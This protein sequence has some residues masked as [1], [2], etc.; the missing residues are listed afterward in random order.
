MAFTLGIRDQVGTLTV[1]ADPK[2][3]A[4][5]L[6]LALGGH[7]PYRPLPSTSPAIDNGVETGGVDQRGVARISNVDSG[8]YEYVP[9]NISGSTGIAGAN[10]TYTDG[11]EKTAT[12]DASGLYSI[13]VPPL[14]TGTVTPS[15][16]GYTFAPSLRS[17]SALLSDQT[18]QDFV[19]SPIVY[20][21][22][23]S[24][25]VAGATLSYD[26][27][28]PKTATADSSGNYSFTVSYNW[29]GTVTPT[30]AGTTFTPANKVYSSVLSN[31]TAQ[32]YLATAITYTISGNAGR[33]RSHPCL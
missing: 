8:A 17:Y 19:A 25:G 2:L 24:V 11:V 3:Q 10:L 31:Q 22:S 29:S 23:G 12:A 13:T 30:K 20:T 18:S 32:D 14:W 6:A 15:R 16:A 1:P 21:V 33:G 5:D 4:L 28:T 9:V 26:D 27:G 7:T